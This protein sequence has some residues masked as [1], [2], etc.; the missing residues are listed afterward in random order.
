MLQFSTSNSPSHSGELS[1]GH[2]PAFN[3]LTV[4]LLDQSLGGSLL[5]FKFRIF[6]TRSFVKMVQL[7][8]ETKVCRIL[9]THCASL[10]NFFFYVQ[11]R[12]S[13]IIDIS[14][15]AIH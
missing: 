12:I 15:V 14:R 13:K 7:S 10:S 11:E 5:T 2:F 4:S 8:E 6:S 3:G 9:T 1:S